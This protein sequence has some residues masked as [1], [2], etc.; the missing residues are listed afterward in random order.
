MT[1]WEA[2]RPWSRGPR[3]GPLPPAHCLRPR[4]DSAHPNSHR[5]LR[6]YPLG[7]GNESQQTIGARRHSLPPVG[8]LQHGPWAPMCRPGWDLHSIPVWD[9][10]QARRPDVLKTTIL[11]A[12]FDVSRPHLPFPCASSYTRTLPNS[13]RGMEP[14]FQGWVSGGILTP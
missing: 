14:P 1:C 9:K 10:H 6:E 13:A 4:A 11:N 3:T 8:P 7:E 5:H 12:I 2:P